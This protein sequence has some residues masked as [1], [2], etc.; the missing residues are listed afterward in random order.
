MNQVII[1][2]GGDTFEDHEEYISFLKNF[3]IDFERY[4]TGKRHWKRTLG[5]RLGEGYE[6][7]MPDMPDKTNAKYAEWKIW[8][9]KFIPYFEPEVILIGH[10]LGGTF[11]IKYLSE[12]TLQKKIR[13]VFLVAACFSDTADYSLADFRLGNDFAGLTAQAAKIFLYHSEDDPVVPFKDFEKLGKLL[14]SATGKAFHDRKHFNQE[15]FPEIV[16]DLRTL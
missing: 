16:H 3:Q 7:I 1:I 8:F 2:H 10:S 4:R 6:V 13:A 15:E 5:E 11:L 12:N 14:P 9:E